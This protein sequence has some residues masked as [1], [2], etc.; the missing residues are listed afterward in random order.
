VS[1]KVYLWGIGLLTILFVIYFIF[2]VFKISPQNANFI[3][4]A[5]FFGSL[6]LGL[7]GIF[8]LAGFYFRA[9]ITKGQV[10]FNYLK[11]A[12]RQG[13]LLSLVVIGLL[14]LK[15]AGVF[16]WWDALLLSGAILL[17]ELYFRGK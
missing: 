2:I 13:L 15:V 11:I 14:L 1:L 4:Y 16:N 17:L 12:I 5:A 3:I 8:S 9:K 7:V 6:F 10:I